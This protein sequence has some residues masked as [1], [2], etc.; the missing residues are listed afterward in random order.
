MNHAI[1]TEDM[2]LT[3]PKRPFPRAERGPLL[4][5]RALAAFVRPAHQKDRMGAAEIP[6]ALTQRLPPPCP[7][8]ASLSLRKGGDAQLGCGSHYSR[9][10]ALGHRRPLL[11]FLFFCLVQLLFT[12]SYATG[13][14]KAAPAD[15]RLGAGDLLRISVFGAP[16]LATEARVSQSGS[17]S[18]PLVG[19]I[20]VSQLSARQVE[21]MLTAHLEQGGFLRSPQV[22]VYVLE[23][24]SQMISVM[25][26]V[27]KPGQYALQRAS[28]VLDVLATA[29]GPINAE[30]ADTAN[31]IRPDGTKASIDL[32]ALFSGDP[33]QNVLV[34]GGDTLYVPRAA[35][36]Y[37][38]G[39]VQKP[40]MYKLERNMTVSRAISAG[41]GLTARGS[42]RH[43]LI[44][45]RAAD[46]KEQDFDARGTDLL[47]PDDVLLVK[48]GWF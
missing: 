22:S 40:G 33:A 31:L 8:P 48:E 1:P 20:T 36:F 43:V 29:G 32:V 26:H 35:Q 6:S 39:E 38:Y 28:R 44:K 12:T 16:E 4:R 9:R 2:A 30:A 11:A 46:G 5:I 21:S 25:G 47:K 15:Y 19:E 10:E 17:I 13:E 3:Q 42:E 18:F 41:G 27:A 23:Y 14:D 37:V 7:S 45:R 34:S 24:Q